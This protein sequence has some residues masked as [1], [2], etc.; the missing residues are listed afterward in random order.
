MMAMVLE[1][2]LAKVAGVEWEDGAEASERLPRTTPMMI[3]GN[4]T[5][6]LTLTHVW[7]LCTAQP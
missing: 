4:F 7:S 6:V 3:R 2:M 5:D 1:T